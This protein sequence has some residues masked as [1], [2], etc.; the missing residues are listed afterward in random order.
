MQ[1]LLTQKQCAE[2]L[3]LSERTLERLR[4][5]GTGPKFIRI[6]HSIRYRPE[7]VQSWLA[8]RIVSSTSEAAE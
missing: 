6:G 4:T 5:M 3:G 7:D 8:S 2:M 1:P